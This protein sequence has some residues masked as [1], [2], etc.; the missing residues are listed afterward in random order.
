MILLLLDF[1][2]NQIVSKHVNFYYGI[3]L[4]PI[5]FVLVL[6]ETVGTGIILPSK[7]FLLWDEISQK[8]S[9]EIVTFYGDG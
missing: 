9:P 2:C 5:L 1:A 3:G 8:L 4:S 6:K 7:Y